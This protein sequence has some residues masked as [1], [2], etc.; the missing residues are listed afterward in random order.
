MAVGTLRRRTWPVWFRQGRCRRLRAIGDA[1]GD[2]RG[3]SGLRLWPLPIS[4][5]SFQG[6]RCDTLLRLNLGRRDRV[7]LRRSDRRQSFADDPLKGSVV[8]AK[9]R[10][11]ERCFILVAVIGL[12]A[13]LRRE[14]GIGA[15]E[16]GNV[17]CDVEAVAFG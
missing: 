5:K 15:F 16:D 11:R 13:T 9:P 4:S 10:Q 17:A 2:R 8:A 7:G 1:T 6:K 3:L 12:H 14:T